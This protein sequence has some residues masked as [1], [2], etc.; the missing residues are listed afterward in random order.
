MGSKVLADKHTLQTEECK[1][2]WI[3]CCKRFLSSSSSSS[4]S[5]SSSIL[6]WKGER[7]KAT[8]SSF[9]TSHSGRS[10]AVHPQLGMCSR[11][12]AVTSASFTCHS[13]VRTNTLLQ[14]S[15]QLQG[16]WHKFSLSLPHILS[17]IPASHELKKKKSR[18]GW[19]RTVATSWKPA[20]NTQQVLD[21]P[22]L[23]SEI[24]TKINE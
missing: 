6:S 9:V 11:V 1:H 7:T 21:H 2:V 17:K 22:K 8:L 24:L 19:G 18:T 20:W 3:C 14:Q 10:A 15:P 5:S 23:H 4:F 16:I 12:S 13:S